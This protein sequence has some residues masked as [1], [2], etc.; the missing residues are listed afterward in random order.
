MGFVT[1]K[2]EKTGQSHT[3]HTSQFPDPDGPYVRWLPDK[4]DNEAALRRHVRRLQEQNRLLAECLADE[5]RL[6]KGAYNWYRERLG[7]WFYCLWDAFITRH[8]K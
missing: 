8:V 7:S 4:K 5:R 2:D 3:I 6:R 1:I